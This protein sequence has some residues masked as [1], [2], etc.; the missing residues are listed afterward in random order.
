MANYRGGR[1]GA[2]GRRARSALGLRIDEALVRNITCEIVFSTNANYYIIRPSFT[3]AIYKTYWK[4]T[5]VTGLLKFG[6]DVVTLLNPVVL[7]RIIAFIQSD[8]PMSVGLLWATG[9][10]I[11]YLYLCPLSLLFTFSLY[12]LIC[13]PNNE[14]FF[15]ESPNV[16][17]TAW[18][19][20]GNLINFT[21]F[22]VNMY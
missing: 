4:S 9:M 7:E 22:F 21:N 5:I 19:M 10:F 8:D 1:G 18:W 3:L 17:G 12:S 15:H 13:M 6:S 16:D 20:E 11:F 2:S 14:D